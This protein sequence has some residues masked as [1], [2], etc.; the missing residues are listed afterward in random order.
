M[1]HTL[2]SPNRAGLL[3]YLVLSHFPDALILASLDPDT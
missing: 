1:W 2:A 3:Q